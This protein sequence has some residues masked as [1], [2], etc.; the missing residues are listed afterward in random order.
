MSETVQRYDI[1][2]CS[3]NPYES[4]RD[5]VR[6]PDGDW[7]AYDDYAA[8]AQRLADVAFLEAWRNGASESEFRWID[9]TYWHDC[10][11]RAYARH[12]HGG[13]PHLVASA[14]TLPALDAWLRAIR[15]EGGR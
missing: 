7:V 13:A 8:L 9:S 11:Y 2:D 12:P 10:A 15:E 14:P 3:T 1:E 6:A 5:L 4:Y